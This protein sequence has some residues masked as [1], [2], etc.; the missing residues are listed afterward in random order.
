MNMPTHHRGPAAEVQALEAYIKLMRAA[1]TLTA[2]TSRELAAAGLTESQFGVLE[3]LFHLGPLHQC[4]LATKLLKS[5]PNITLV[6]DNLEKRGLI[7]REKTAEDRRAT[8]IRL[9]PD[10]ER[11][12]RNLFPR[13]AAFISGLMAA[14]DADEQRA[15]AG[16]CRKLGTG[17][18]QTSEA[19]EKPA[20]SR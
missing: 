4:E 8:T 3:V 12:I 14:L 2:R 17:I 13:H 6:A 10:G 1:N 20:A 7:Q 16:L 11:Y 5:G 18:P 15:L 9:T 19:A